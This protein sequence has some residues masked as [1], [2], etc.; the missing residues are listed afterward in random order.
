MGRDPRTGGWT[1]S[2]RRPPVEAWAD[3]RHV[4]HNTET[5]SIDGADVTDSTYLAVAGSS[6]DPLVLASRCGPAIQ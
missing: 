5:S 2:Y 4:E 6:D 1:G 3:W